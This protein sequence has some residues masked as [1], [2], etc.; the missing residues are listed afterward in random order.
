MNACA[1]RAAADRRVDGR[2][3]RSRLRQAPGALRHCPCHCRVTKP[4]HCPFR[5]PVTALSLPLSLPF[6]CP[7]TAPVAVLSLPST[8]LPLS[9][10]RV[11]PS[12]HALAPPVRGSCPPP[13]GWRFTA[14]TTHTRTPT[15]SFQI[16]A[17][18][19]ATRCLQ[20]NRRRHRRSGDAGPGP[21]V[22]I[23]EDGEPDGLHEP[24]GRRAQHRREGVHAC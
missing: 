11:R 15:Q 20:H 17:Q 8:A 5:C 19:L 9:M 3:A 6:H 4:W 2:S 13:A 18:P 24:A 21:A 12:P 14:H 22:L 10:E 16:A 1:H 7:F 23:Q